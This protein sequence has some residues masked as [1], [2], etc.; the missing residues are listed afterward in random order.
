MKI[1]TR[2]FLA[3]VCTQMYAQVPLVHSRVL[4]QASEALVQA[5]VEADRVGSGPDVADRTSLPDAPSETVRTTCT[6]GSG[7]PCPEWVHKLI[8]QYPPV[9]E[10]P[11]VW[12]HQP[13]HFFTVGNGRRAL[14]PDKKSWL[15]FT[16]A[17]AGMWAAAV[18]AVSRH[19]T[20]HE[21]A[22]SEYPAVAFMTGL[23]FL[24]F[25]T[26]SPALSV[27]PPVYATVHYSLAA[28]K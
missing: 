1:L 14:H 8:G 9:R 27:G 5:N 3:F 10:V 7:T 17:H 16:A 22:H 4:I 24:F 2:L 15:L 21:E 19:R 20:S 28:A 12:N 26:L 6:Q 23:D 18:V 13:D 11:E 25:K